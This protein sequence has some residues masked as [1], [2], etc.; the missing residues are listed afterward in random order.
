ML[1]VLYDYEIIQLQKGLNVQL[2]INIRCSG[3]RYGQ[4]TAVLI[5][6]WFITAEKSLQQCLDFIEIYKN[7]GGPLS[8][9]DENQNTPLMLFLSSSLLPSSCDDQMYTD[10]IIDVLTTNRTIINKININGVTPMIKAASVGD[11]NC[12]KKL[13]DKGAKINIK[14]RQ[15]NSILHLSTIG[16]FNEIL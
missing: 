1:F 13:F 12:I 14:D 15:G 9:M 5:P 10:T 4:W 16:K 7:H 2:Q 3:E 6:A 8:D 11:Y